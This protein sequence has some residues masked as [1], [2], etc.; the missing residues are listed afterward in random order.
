M[1]KMKKQRNPMVSKDGT[2]RS[3]D[4]QQITGEEQNRRFSRTGE[5]DMT[6]PNPRSSGRADIE[7]IGIERLRL[8]SGSKKKT[9][10]ATWNIRSMQQGKLDIV[11]LEME[12]TRIDILGISELKWTGIGHFQS[13]NHTVY[14]S[15]NENYRQSGVAF[16]VNKAI[17]KSVLGYNTANDRIISI[18]IQASPCNIT[19]IQV[20]APTTA[21]KTEE[22]D[23]FYHEL[24]NVMDAAPP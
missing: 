5:N 17:Q 4:T 9:N 19:I 23:N 7:E 10:I 6:A 14:F 24:Q 2:L 15:G 3:N 1:N 20:Y 21:A 11:K 16:V 13:D 8:S 22:T 12:R 18:R